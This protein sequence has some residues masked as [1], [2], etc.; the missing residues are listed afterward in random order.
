MTLLETTRERIGGHQLRVA[1]L[2]AHGAG[3]PIVLLHG[4]PENLQ[5]WCEL[6]P[7]L[8]A[9]GHE[10]VA[11]DWPGLG[12]SDPWPGGLTPQHLGRRLGLLLD[13]W[14]IER[15]VIVGLDM[16]G[17]PA[18]ACAAEMPGRVA[19]VVVMNSLVLGDEA[20]S[21]EIRVLRRD[22]WN[23][24]ILRYL[25]RL[26]LTRAERTFLPP[27]TRL[28]P[29]LRAE[30]WRSFRRPA[31]RDTIARM[32]AGYQAFIPR[33]ASLYPAIRRPVLALWGERDRHFP[34]AQA[35]RLCTSLRDGRFA[36]VP[37][38]EHWMAWHDPGAV[39]SRIVEFLGSIEE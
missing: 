39:A 12:E 20:T 15:A 22:G 26:V 31:V 36:V 38:G 9:A 35:E 17:Q 5:I 14:R 8:A 21:R 3:P 6:A 33:L 30:I 37:G 34:P 27:G 13:A 16:G 2:G 4:Y 28:A 1:R 11:L 29:E 10:V 24:L 19:A 7:L 25:P 18:L 32:C 23:R